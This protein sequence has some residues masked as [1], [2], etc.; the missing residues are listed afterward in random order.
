MFVQGDPKFSPP[1]RAK[2]ENFYEKLTNAFSNKIYLKIIWRVL[3]TGIGY[4]R[5]TESFAKI[6]SVSF[7]LCFGH[8]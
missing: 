6:D 3:T 8:F 4:L 1:S 7:L 5:H 2:I